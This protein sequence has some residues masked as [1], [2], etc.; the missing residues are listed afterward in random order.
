MEVWIASSNKGKVREIGAFLSEH[1]SF[2]FEVHSQDEIS[3]YFP[4]PETGDSFEANARIKARGLRALKTSHWVLAD[5]SGLE[6]EGLNHFPG[7]HSARYAGDRATDVENRAKLLKMINLRCAMN[8]RAKFRCVIVAY[9]PEGVEYV[10]EGVLKGSISHQMKG[11]KGFGYDPLFIPEGLEKTMAEIE[12]HEKNEMSHR[13][14]ALSQF[15]EIFQR[16]QKT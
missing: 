4:P 1:V 14:R 10:V 8:R 7:V 12:L 5:D 15:T 16:V 2:P 6:A 13:G 11:T 9:S 3:V